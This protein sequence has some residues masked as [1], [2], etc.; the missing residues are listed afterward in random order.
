[1]RSPLIT[2][3]A[4]LL[5]ALPAPG[6]AAPRIPERDDE[7]LARLPAGPRS[8][9]V[10]RP[11]RP[12][13]LEQA[14]S[15]ARLLLQQAQQE[16]DPRFLGYAEAR[17]APWRDG[18]GLPAELHLLRARLYQARHRFAPAQVALST[19][20]AQAPDLAEAWLLK[21]GLE[22]LQGDY[23]AALAS[24]RRVSG[25]EYLSLS[26]ACTAQVQGLTGQAPQALLTLQKLAAAPLGLSAG[27]A[28]WLQLG[29]ADVA[30][31]LGR[32]AQ[33]EAALRQAQPLGAEAVASYADWL[34][35]QGRHADTLRLLAPWSSHEGL[36]IYQLRARLALGQQLGAGEVAAL[37]GRLQAALRPGE[38]PHFREQALLALD[39]KGQ[40]AAAL[41]MARQNWEVQKEPVDTRLYARA[42]HAAQSATDLARLQRWQ[43]ATAYQDHALNGFLKGGPYAP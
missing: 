9:G 41:G 39:I 32:A 18:P 8:P 28:A 4:L 40:P 22:Q 2:G 37:A 7:V 35:R 5:L 30:D 42:A 21:A 14:L 27:Q 13:S 36:L 29:L 26:L 15:E 6:V 34:W 19:A 11:A 24:C 31:R 38:A 1:M 23:R 3:L 33:A 12:P 43:R 20:L 16:A 25:L 17:L 10:S